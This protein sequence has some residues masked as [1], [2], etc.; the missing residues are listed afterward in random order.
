MH[1]SKNLLN[2]NKKK[3]LKCKKNKNKRY[4]DILLLNYLQLIKCQERRE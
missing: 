1:Y 4:N 3:S 2:P